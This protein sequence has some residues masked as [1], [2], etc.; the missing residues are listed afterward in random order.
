M[1]RVFSFLLWPKR[2]AHLKYLLVQPRGPTHI[3]YG[4]GTR[5]IFFGSE[6][7]AKVD[8]FGSTKDAGIFFGREKNTGIFWVL[9][10][11]S[12]QIN[13]NIIPIYCWCGIW[14]VCCTRR[15]FGGRQILKLVFFGV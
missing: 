9:Y 12:A 8:N 4:W 3:F 14:G 13:N 11:S 10:F 7:L 6:L 2:E 15:G 1:D 5:G